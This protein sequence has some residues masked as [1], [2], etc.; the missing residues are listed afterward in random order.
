MS[1]VRGRFAPSTTGR[2]HPGTL[3]AALLCWLDAR[4]LGG[5]VFL[6]LEDLDRE[7]TKAGYVDAMMDDLAWLGLDWD[8]LTRQSDQTSRYE[9]K[10]QALV[11]SGR[12]YEC[13]CSRAEIRESAKRAPDGSYRYSGTC[14][15]RVVEGD[16]W[17]R[18]AQPLRVRLDAGRIEIRD[19]SGLDLSGDPLALFGDP[20][21][22]GREGAF[23]YHFVSV[24]DDEAD[25]INRVVRGR[26]L[27]P[28]TTLQAGLRSLF[29]FE[30]PAYRHHA[31]LL[32]GA[33]GKFSKFHG[34]VNIAEL[35]GRYDAQGLC[36]ALAY[37][38]GLAP[39]GARCTPADLVSDFEWSRVTSADVALVWSREEGL[40]LDD[41]GEQ[42]S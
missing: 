27:A 5:E 23:S 16:A 22:R 17:R 34:A 26:D 18:L 15:D 41:S 21:V 9:A 42:L 1:N 36:G 2:A 3:F 10:L 6:R 39:A 8:G 14:R 4:K 30:T 20:L 33:A 29:G 40:S 32:E 25:G 37:Y 11:S 7:R 31:L 12:I 24:I 38:A 13:V 19:Q 35:T 28:S